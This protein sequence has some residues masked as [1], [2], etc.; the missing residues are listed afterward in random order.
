MGDPPSRSCGSQFSVVI[1]WGSSVTGLLQVNCNSSF[2][3][4]VR[5]NRL[6]GISMSAES[7]A[8]IVWPGYSVGE[9]SNP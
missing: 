8:W 2:A 6:T 1:W 3:P 7:E 9:A 4:Y 5:M